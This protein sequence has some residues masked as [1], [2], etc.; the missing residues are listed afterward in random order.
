MLTDSDL[1]RSVDIFLIVLFPGM[2]YLKNVISIGV[3]FANYF[4]INQ[5]L[6]S[7]LS[8]SLD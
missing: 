8:F 1:S 3:L 7:V 6:S 2:L 5:S 4:A